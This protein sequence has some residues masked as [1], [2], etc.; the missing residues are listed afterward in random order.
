[1]AKVRRDVWACDAPGCS[2]EIPV[3]EDAPPGYSGIVSTLGGTGCH[4]E[5]FFACKQDHITP[6]I[7]EV[8]RSAHERAWM[9]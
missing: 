7:V 4:K 2:V 8:A 1:M 9:Q 5:P 3:S 6:A